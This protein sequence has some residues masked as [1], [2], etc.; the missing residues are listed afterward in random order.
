MDSQG[1]LFDDAL[2][3]S[4]FS[5]FQDGNSIYLNYVVIPEPSSW[6]LLA[7]ALAIVLF[8]GPRRRFHGGGIRQQG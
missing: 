3:L 6:A 2:P 1:L 8:A 4:E 5:L 7:S